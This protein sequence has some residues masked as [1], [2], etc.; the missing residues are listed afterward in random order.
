VDHEEFR[1]LALEA[2]AAARRII[3]VSG[4]GDSWDDTDEDADVSLFYKL[5]DKLG[6]TD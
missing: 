2:I 6:I 1:T 5:C 3:S 4:G